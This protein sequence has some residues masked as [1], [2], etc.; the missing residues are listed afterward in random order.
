MELDV[1]TFLVTVYV[2][3]ADL[4]R[5]RFAPRKPRRPGA[6][7]ELSDEEVLTLVLLAQW[8]PQR[9]ERAFLRYAA[10]HWRAYFPRLLHQSAFNRRA[11]DLGQVLAALGPA[12]ATLAR[13]RLGLARAY[14][15]WDG[16]P[17]PLE[18]PCRARRSHLFGDAAGF[19]RGGADRELYYGLHLF[20]ALDP[21][22]LITGFVLGPAATSEYWLAEALLA[23]RDDPG[24][25]TP[26]ATE[27]APLLGPRHCAGGQRAGVTGPLGPRVAAGS[28]S[29]APYVS[30]LGLAGERWREH[31]RADY[32]A[33]VLTK[34]EY[35]ALAD[36]AER[37]RW[38]GWL[39]GLRQQVETAFNALTQ[40]FW[41]KFPRART[42]WGAWTRLA[43]KVAAYNIAVF[44]NHLFGRPTFAL[45]DPLA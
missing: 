8:L 38:T 27:L 3:V 40:T 24:A 2:L 15:V 30:D 25:P 1:D 39:C 13:Q 32:G 14:Q 26:T 19:G 7:P 21:H 6:R 34:A 20:A 33:A 28:A 16:L 44:V 12:V 31:W 9:S 17:I 22:G 29:A 18:R 4:Y 10:A 5:E 11:R 37:R 45:F 23:W 35:A 36:P 42:V 43:A 41:A